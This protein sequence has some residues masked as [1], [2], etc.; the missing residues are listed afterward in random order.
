MVNHRHVQVPHPHTD[1]SVLVGREWRPHLCLSSGVPGSAAWHALSAPRLSLGWVCPCAPA[2]LLLLPRGAPRP[3]SL[4]HGVSSLSP[5]PDTKH[6]TPAPLLSRA[7]GAGICT[8]SL[9]ALGWPSLSASCSWVAGGCGSSPSAAVQRMV[10]RVSA[11]GGASL[12]RR[13]RHV[14]PT[15]MLH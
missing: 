1:P 9:L 8:L 11:A 3:C 4:A 2:R 6:P 10:V 7:Y 15:W 5:L 13:Q 14:Y 12:H